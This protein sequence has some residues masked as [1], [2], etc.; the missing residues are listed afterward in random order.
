MHMY[1]KYFHQDKNKNNS[2]DEG[3]WNVLHLLLVLCPL[4]VVLYIFKITQK[5]SSVFADISLKNKNKLF[6]STLLD[7]HYLLTQKEIYNF[8]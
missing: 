5:M 3:C 7:F 4:P 1:T 6:Q 8:L 2:K